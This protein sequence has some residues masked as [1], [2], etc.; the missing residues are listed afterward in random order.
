[1]VS[2]HLHAEGSHSDDHEHST[3][4]SIGESGKS[5]DASRAIQIKMFDKY[6]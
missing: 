5:S 1:M 6:Y 3:K 2:L 4:T